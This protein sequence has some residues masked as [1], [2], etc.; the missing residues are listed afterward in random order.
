MSRRTLLAV[1]VVCTLTAGCSVSTVS[2]GA[3]TATDRGAT[4][5]RATT[6]GDVPGLNGSHVVDASALVDAHGAVLDG[7]AVTETRTAALS[8]DNGTERGATTWTTRY[9]A[10]RSTAVV[11]RVGTGLVSTRGRVDRFQNESTTVT[12]AFEGD[13]PVYSAD[14]WRA[15]GGPSRTTGLLTSYLRGPNGSAR[16][17]AST[18]VGVR[19]GHETYRLRLEASSGEGGRLTVLVD[20]RGFL[21]AVRS[22]RPFGEG[23]LTSVQSARCVLD[24]GPV[25]RPA[26]VDAAANATSD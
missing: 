6:V 14:G 2:D 23:S 1:L 20:E 7:R 10:D 8:Y 19:D 22:E 17:F 26:W 5:T 12:R 24:T 21:R 15:V 25:E 11:D 13:E 18:Y 3:G 16:S 4:P 9:S